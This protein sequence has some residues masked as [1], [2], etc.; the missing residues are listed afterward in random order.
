MTKPNFQIKLYGPN[1]GELGPNFSKFQGFNQLFK[2]ESL[3]S[4][5]F[6][7]FKQADMMYNDNGGPVAKKQF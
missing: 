6:A 1:F 5:D 7:Y 4:S 3:N 2:F